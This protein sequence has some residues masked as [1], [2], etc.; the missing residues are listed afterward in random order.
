MSKQF[1]PKHSPFIQ[2]YPTHNQH[3]SIAFFRFP[4]TKPLELKARPGPF[5]FFRS[6]SSAQPI[7]SQ[8]CEQRLYSSVIFGSWKFQEGNQGNREKKP[9]RHDRTSTFCEPARP[10]CKCLA[11]VSTTGWGTGW[12][13]CGGKAKNHKKS[14]AN[15]KDKHT[16]IW[17]SHGT[18]SA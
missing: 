1:W 3:A 17:A 12:L 13:P 11:P 4:V 9:T 2:P 14:N 7:T 15:R 18:K 5:S 16:Y 8:S 10:T 6:Q